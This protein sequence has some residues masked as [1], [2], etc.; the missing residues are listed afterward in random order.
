M[1]FKIILLLGIF[2][3]FSHVLLAQYTD[4][5]HRI[6]QI[7]A[8]YHTG[9][10]GD[11]YFFSYNALLQLE[12]AHGKRF[13]DRFALLGSVGVEENKDGWL[14]PIAM[15]LHQ[16]IGKKRQQHIQFQLGYG[17]GFRAASAT[18]YDYLGGLLGGFDYGF[19]LFKI[20]K[21]RVLAAASYQWR[22]TALRYTPFADG[23]TIRQAFDNH[24]F[25][26]RTSLEF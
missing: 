1:K 14:L 11:V 23:R 25:G 4:F 13:N 10:S 9:T 17:I 12:F 5:P 21:T 8:A 18:D 16:R 26:V 19:Q 7:R 24:Y 22:R 15:N 6:S 20:K 3:G 2:C